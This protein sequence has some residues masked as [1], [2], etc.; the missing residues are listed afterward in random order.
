MSKAELRRFLAGLKPA[1]A[2]LLRLRL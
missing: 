1:D 2:G